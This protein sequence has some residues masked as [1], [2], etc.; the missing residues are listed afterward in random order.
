MFPSIVT[1]ANVVDEY[2][3]QETSLTTDPKSYVNIGSLL[4][5]DERIIR[6]IDLFKQRQALLVSVIPDFHVPIAWTCNENVF[7]ERIPFDGID[8]HV[9]SVE[10]GEQLILVICRVLVYLALFGSNEK[11]VVLERVEIKATSVCL[12]KFCWRE[13][14]SS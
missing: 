2:G 3:A 7:G 13:Y 5:I 8:R 12:K 6:W 11:Q 14:I 10:N 1:A 9:M 4:M